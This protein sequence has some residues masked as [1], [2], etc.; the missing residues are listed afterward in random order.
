MSVGK[1]GITVQGCKLH[2]S[3]SVLMGTP[4]TKFGNFSILVLWRVCEKLCYQSSHIYGNDP[5][6]VKQDVP[7]HL[8][9]RK[10][11]VFTMLW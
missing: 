2:W 1:K 5:L 11:P 10:R 4:E 6:L 9:Y 3:S 8:L 7:H